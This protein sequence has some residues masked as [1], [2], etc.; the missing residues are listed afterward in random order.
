MSSSIAV[1]VCYLC[2]QVFSLSPKHFCQPECDRLTALHRDFC[3]RCK[4]TMNADFEV[5]IHV[6]NSDSA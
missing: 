3:P 6:P 4:R 5:Q 1:F 2:H